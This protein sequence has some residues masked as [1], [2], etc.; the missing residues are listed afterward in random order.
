VG[1]AVVSCDTQIA[2]RIVPAF[3]L[4]CPCVRNSIDR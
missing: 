3:A 4:R 1:L 2:I